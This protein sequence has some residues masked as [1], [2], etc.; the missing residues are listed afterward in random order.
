MSVASKDLLAGG[1]AN[2][3][4]E[5]FRK[6]VAVHWLVKGGHD[7][8]SVA[9]LKYE[10]GASVPRHRHRDLETILVLEGSQSD[11]NGTYGAGTL[12]A[13]LADTR[14]SVWSDEGCVVLIHWTLPVAIEGEAH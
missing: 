8:P 7:T 1:W 10:P 12:I 11:E 9:L 6:G 3:P 2:L 4:F 14:H 5:F 13:N